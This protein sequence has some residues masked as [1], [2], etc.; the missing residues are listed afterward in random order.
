MKKYL[1]ILRECPLFDGI[2][3]E[4]LLRMLVCRGATVKSFPQKSTVFAEGDRPHLIGIVL[5]GSAQIIQFDYNGN[6]NIISTVMPSELFCEAFALAKTD[7]LP[8]AVVTSEESEVMFIEAQRVTTTCSNNCGFH[9]RLIYNLMKDLA[10]KT[11]DYHKRIG[12][13]SKR[14]TRDKLLEY[15][16]IESKRVG[17][18]SFDIPFDRQE[19]A[20]YLEVERSGLSAEIGKMRKEGILESR[21]N[22]FTLFDI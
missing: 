21:K 20:D 13:T 3:D 8:V 17:K 5:S 2:D 19:L 6:K 9:Q 10:C 15:L 11:I 22:H 1:K 18:R 14:T 12:I 7:S 4:E 16:T